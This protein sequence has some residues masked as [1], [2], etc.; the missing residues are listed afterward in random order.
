MAEFT[1]KVPRRHP[2]DRGIHGQREARN[3]QQVGL[4]GVIFFVWIPFMASGV[5]G[6]RH[7][8]TLSRMQFMRVLLATL[9]GGS[10]A[11]VT[12][13]Y[14]AEGIVKFMHQ[15]KLEVFIPLVIG[16]FILMAVLHIRSTKMRRQTELFEDTLLGQLPCGHHRQIRRPVGGWHG[17]HDVV[18]RSRWAQRRSCS[19]HPR[20]R[21]GQR[22]CQ[23]WRLH[24]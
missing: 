6:G 5:S 8:R 17:R 18:S 1:D 13:A 7:A 10:I 19:G 11:S 24:G 2:L 16:V 12:W 4:L 9:I 3:D 20:H 21:H 22:P 14:T 23:P 15:Y